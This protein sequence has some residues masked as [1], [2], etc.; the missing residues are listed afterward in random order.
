MAVPAWSHVKWFAPFDVAEAP[1]SANRVLAP[2]F[3][4]TFVAFGLLVFAGF[5]VDRLVARSRRP[6]V[7]GTGELEERLLR[8]GTGAFF[9]ALFTAGGVILTPELK[10]GAEWP[11]WL[12]LG[13]AASMFSARSC[14]LGAVGILA[15]FGYGAAQYGA[16]H[17]AD[18][19]LFL[20]L[21]AFMALTSSRSEQLRAW[22]MPIVYVSACGSL[23]WS[24]IEKWAYPHWFFPLLEE[25]P[26]LAFGLPFEDFVMAAGF[27]EFALAFYIL[28]GLG[29]LRLGIAALGLIFAAAILDFGKLD[30]IGHL[31]I[32]A[33]LAAMYV[34]GPTRLHHWLHDA[35]RNLFT[36]AGRAGVGFAAAIGVFAAA[37]YSLQT[38]EHGGANR[39]QRLEA[40]R[41]SVNQGI[42]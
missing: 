36:E 24:T 33:G 27:V 2:H 18:Y 32:L 42:R 29:L 3:L 20:G 8:A 28:T 39:G 1:M 38:A 23:M 37:Y 12:Q 35:R 11:A 25:R 9:M 4:Q 21:A 41:A 6:G 30:A 34:H 5:L 10:T 15:L 16:F 13:I 22:R 26:H 19:P 40:T 17:I 31:P 7:S 14:V